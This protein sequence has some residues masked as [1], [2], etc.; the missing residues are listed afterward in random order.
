MRRGRGGSQRGA[1]AVEVTLLVPLLCLILGGL[2]G[3]WRVGWARTQVVEA[4]AAGARA[5]TIANSA[6]AALQQST[7]AIEADLMTVGVHCAGLQVDVDT[8]A[9]AQPPGVRGEVT[10]RVSCLL[11]LSDVLVPGLPGA[12][13]ITTAATEPLDIFRER[14]P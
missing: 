8:S 7:A 12:L 4:A 3:G 6:G 14:R 2:A 11:N 10:A 9:F 1:A 5:A 13:A